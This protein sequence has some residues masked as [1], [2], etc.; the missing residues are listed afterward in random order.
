MITKKK[1][2][3]KTEEIA[4]LMK[5]PVTGLSMEWWVLKFWKEFHMYTSQYVC[6]GNK[7]ILILALK[8]NKN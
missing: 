3:K 2:K 4:K 8:I 1:K 6:T 7:F 5:F